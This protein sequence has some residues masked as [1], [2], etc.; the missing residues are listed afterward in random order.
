MQLM[1]VNGFLFYLLIIEPIADNFALLAVWLVHRCLIHMR[2]MIPHT[3]D[4]WLTTP[5]HISPIVHKD[6]FTRHTKHRRRDR[7]PFRIRACAL[8]SVIDDLKRKYA[9]P[10]DHR[11]DTDSYIH[12]MCG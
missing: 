9:S 7:D 2:R 1:A 8:S 4:V 6:S 3:F 10:Q 5:C 11:Y 12:L